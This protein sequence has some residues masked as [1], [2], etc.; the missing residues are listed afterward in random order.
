[1]GGNLGAESDTQPPGLTSEGRAAERTCRVRP[2]RP[3][4]QAGLGQGLGRAQRREAR[5]GS[6]RRPE[7]AADC[8]AGGEPAA[9]VRSERQ[10]NA[11]PPRAPRAPRDG[12]AQPPGGGRGEKGQV[13]GG[14]DRGAAGAGPG[15]ASCPRRDADLAARGEKSPR[16]EKLWAAPDAPGSPGSLLH[17]ETRTS[18]CPRGDDRPG[19]LG[20]ERTPRPRSRD[21]GAETDGARA[22]QP[23]TL[24][25]VCWA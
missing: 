17:T 3:R 18:L 21:R 4:G 11:A 14:E 25:T 12:G 2:P 8:A 24:T 22:R 10:V 16:G 6:P 19:V 5:Q 7:A 15:S 9:R 23:R 1:M 20:T 13:P